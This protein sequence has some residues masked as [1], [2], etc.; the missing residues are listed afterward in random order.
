MGDLLK[1]AKKPLP[2][3]IWGIIS[4]FLQYKDRLTLEIL[5]K[6][7]RKYVIPYW[8]N[9]SVPNMCVQ[10]SFLSG[11]CSEET[12]KDGIGTFLCSYKFYSL[13]LFS[14]SQMVRKETHV[15]SAIGHTLWLGCHRWPTLPI[16]HDKYNGY[17]LL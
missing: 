6:Q 13:W 15:S 8:R 4:S 5:S 1:V 12:Y 10:M 17:H 14:S 11:N 3:E 9:C 16:D 2:P 7:I